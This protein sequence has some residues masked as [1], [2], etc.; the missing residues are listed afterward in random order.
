MSVIG[1]FMLK[2]RAEALRCASVG[3]SSKGDDL[4]ED[5]DPKIP[6]SA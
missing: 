4:L 2:L 5:E 6:P 1:Y 3:T